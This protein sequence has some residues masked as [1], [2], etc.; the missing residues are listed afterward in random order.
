MKRYYNVTNVPQLWH[1][2]FGIYQTKKQC[3]IEVTFPE[4][5]NSKRVKIQLYL[6]E[7]EKDDI[8]PKYDLIIGN[9]VMHQLGVVLDFKQKFIT[10]DQIELPMRERHEIESQSKRLQ[11]YIES[12]FSEPHVTECETERVLRILDAKYEKADLDK[13]VSD[14]NHLEKAE[15]QKLLRL[16][17]KFEELFDGTLGEWK[18]TPAHLELKDGA[19]PYHGRP[20]PVP[21]IQKEMLR[22]EVD[23]LEKLGVLKREDDSEHAYPSFAQ[24]KPGSMKV[25]FLSDFRFNAL[26]VRHSDLNK[27]ILS[28]VCVMDVRLEA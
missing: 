3:D 22:K 15:K 21:H 12:F 1:T 13:V 24:P 18:T 27:S 5:S 19:T 6:I 25:R 4:Y 28:G 26:S 17:K 9:N 8:G 10:I 7:Y 2:S 11:L 14:C 16:L 20:Y 23:R